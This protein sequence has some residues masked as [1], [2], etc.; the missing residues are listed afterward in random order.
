MHFPRDAGV[1]RS[2]RHC[3][4]TIRGDWV[5]YHLR[6]SP[7]RALSMKFSL[8]VT[9][10]TLLLSVI[11]IT[12]VA[13][14]Y[15]SYRNARFTADDLTHQVLEQTSLRVDHQLNDLLFSANEQSTL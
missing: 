6:S 3:G 10:T 13:L 7:S 12:V 15:N 2:A 8:R 1:V 11:L 9:L 5:L 4:G 14:G